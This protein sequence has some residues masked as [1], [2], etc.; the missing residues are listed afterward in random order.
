MDIYIALF[1]IAVVIQSLPKNKYLYWSFFVILLLVSGYRGLEVGGDTEFYR[2]GFEFVRDGGLF[3]TTIKFPEYSYWFI[4]YL[5]IKLGGTYKQFLFVE[6]FCVLFPL[7]FTAWKFTEKPQRVVGFYYTLYFF[8]FSLCFVRQCIAAGILFSAY[9]IFEKTRNK[10]MLLALILLAGTFHSSAFFVLPIMFIIGK[11]YNVSLGAFIIIASYLLGRT[12]IFFSVLQSL[13][14]TAISHMQI[15]SLNDVSFTIN[16][17]ILTIFIA[18]YLS[19]TNVSNFN[20]Y[21]IAIGVITINLFAFNT[22]ISRFSWN[23][24][25]L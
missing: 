13:N 3:N 11:K 19:T 17:F 1:V 7:F 6:S 23:F 18:W 20:A 8:C 16:G 14:I 15:E 9:L 25:I 12:V 2:W 24:T 21:I 5:T 10:K 4:N 22:N